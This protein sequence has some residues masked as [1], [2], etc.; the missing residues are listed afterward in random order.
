MKTEKIDF[1]ALL[2]AISEVMPIEF[3]F[4]VGEIELMNSALIKDTG[5]TLKPSDAWDSF[6]NPDS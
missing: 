3:H 4:S 1:N 5:T 6:I 2:F